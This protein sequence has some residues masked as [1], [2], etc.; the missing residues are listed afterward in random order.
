MALDG[1][2]VISA[3]IRRQPLLCMAVYAGKMNLYKNRTNLY[4]LSLKNQ[5]SFKILLMFKST[6]FTSFRD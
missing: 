5:V 3:V 4:F 1:T 2:D 6:A